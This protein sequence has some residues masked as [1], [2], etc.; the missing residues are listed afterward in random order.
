MA[1]KKQQSVEV[2]DKVFEAYPGIHKELDWP[3]GWEKGDNQEIIGELA[4]W[5][6]NAFFDGN[7][8]SVKDTVLHETLNSFKGDSDNL[9]AFLFLD[10]AEY[11]GGAFGNDGKIEFFS[12]ATK[13]KLI[14]VKGYEYSFSSTSSKK[15]RVL[16]LVF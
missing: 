13:G 11:G 10:T 4:Q 9:K 12:A 16:E 3:I 2:K 14:I 8:L 5:I 1:K 6:D 7:N 15:R